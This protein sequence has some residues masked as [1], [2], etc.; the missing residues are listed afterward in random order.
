MPTPAW[1]SQQCAASASGFRGRD[2]RLDAAR[3]ALE[4]RLLGHGRTGR[5]RGIRR[6]CLGRDVARAF[7]ARTATARRTRRGVRIARRTRARCIARRRVRIARRTR[8]RACITRRRVR[9][10]RRTAFALRA[11]RAGTRTGRTAARAAGAAARATRA[12]A[13]TARTTATAA[14]LRTTAAGHASARA[15]RK[16]SAMLSLASPSALTTGARGARGIGVSSSAV[17]GST[18][19]FCSM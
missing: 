11:T 13:R 17:T 6:R 8:S 5:R 15:S 19:I 3:E 10:T 9:I 12:A 1:R 4:E 7:R 18:G 16:M 14:G 2:Q